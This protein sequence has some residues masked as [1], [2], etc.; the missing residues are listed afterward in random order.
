MVLRNLIPRKESKMP[1]L[2]QKVAEATNSEAGLV[3]P[4]LILGSKIKTRGRLRN[5]KM[6]QNVLDFFVVC[7]T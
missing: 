2:D 6:K 5:G 4:F 1:Y 3:F 7:L